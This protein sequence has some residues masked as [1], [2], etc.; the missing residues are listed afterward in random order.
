[1]PP[2]TLPT[3]QRVGGGGGVTSEASRCPDRVLADNSVLAMNVHLL[4]VRP[5]LLLFIPVFVLGRNELA[6]P[7]IMG[8]GGCLYSSAGGS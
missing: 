8:V 7:V 4:Y 6:L 5:W 3:G 2:L 1:M